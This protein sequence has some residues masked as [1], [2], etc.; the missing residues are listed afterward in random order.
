MLF[1]VFSLDLCC[2]DFGFGWVLDS[3]YLLVGLFGFGFN[4]TYYV[5]G[6][7]V[8]ECFRLVR[9]LVLRL[10]VVIVVWWFDFA[11]WCCCLID[12][13]GLWVGG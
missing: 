12:L 2:A 13:L 5:S 3:C 10:V 8:V 7:C 9:V 6:F 4:G 11:F 1:R